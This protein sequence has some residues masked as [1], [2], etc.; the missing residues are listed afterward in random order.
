MVAIAS[1]LL[2]KGIFLVL[3]QFSSSIYNR[4]FAC[5]IAKEALTSIHG[6]IT[7]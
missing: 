3:E 4:D 2:Y 1:Y 5:F 6:Y 7:T